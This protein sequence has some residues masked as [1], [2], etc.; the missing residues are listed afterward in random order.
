MTTSGKSDTGSQLL[1]SSWQII[2]RQPRLLFFP[3]IS[4]AAL[5]VIG[6]FYMPRFNDMVETIQAARTAHHDDLWTY[7]LTVTLQP[8]NFLYWVLYY[9]LAMHISTFVN[10]AFYHEIFRA[11]ESEPVSLRGGLQFARQRLRSIILWSL[12]ASSV[13]IFLRILGSKMSW[14]GR[15]ATALT[16]LTWSVVAVFV[17]PVII[18][19]ERAG[20][21]TLLRSSAFT[22]KKTWGESIIGFAKIQFYALF[23]LL[24]FALYLGLTYDTPAGQAP[25]F[26]F[27]KMM[28]I[29]FVCGTVTYIANS[30]YRCALYIYATEGVVPEPFTPELMD[31]AWKVKKP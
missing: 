16:G 1:R 12:F 18:H 6:L 21:L 8:S 26:L 22:L 7:A 24:G 28:L 3:M 20:P 11:M 14:T 5:L 13:G 9:M 2:K 27:L 10:V 29:S 31:A 25:K 15:I 30:V 19:D 4:G 17:I 23:G